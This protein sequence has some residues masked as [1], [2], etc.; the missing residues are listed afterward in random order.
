MCE[1]LDVAARAEAVC[2]SLASTVRVLQEGGE[3]HV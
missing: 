2:T 3:S 1:A